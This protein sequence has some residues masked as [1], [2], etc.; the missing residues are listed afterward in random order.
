MTITQL[1]SGSYRIRQMYKG[2]TY[3]KVLPYKPTKKEAITIMAEMMENTPVE[4]SAAPNR[5]LGGAIEHFIAE[6]EKAGISPAS[7]RGY[8]VI[9]RNIPQK[10][11][12]IVTS[13]ITNDDVQRLVNEYGKTRTAKT[14][15]NMYSLVRSSLRQ[16]RPNLV[17]VCNLP[18]AERKAE[19]EPTTED[20]RRILEAAKGSRYEIVL[21]L[22]ALAV[23]RGE[24]I[25]VTAADLTGNVL[26]INKD[27]VLDKNENY[28]LKDRPKNESSNRRILLPDSLANLIREKG[29]AFEGNPH[30]INEYLHKLQDRLGIPRF[31]LH[32]MR[33]FAVAYL[34][35]EGFTEEQIMNWGGWSTSSV[36]KRAYRYNLD[37][38]ESQKEISNRLGNLNF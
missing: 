7:V 36:M 15:R 13:D 27:V 20:I 25:A 26:T 10:Y 19:Y 31:R 3:S 8:L 2:H 30:T 16:I 35:K 21:R 6:R 33:H 17:L 14:V 18:S 5:T 4:A 9:Y 28:V 34:H 38:E 12:N 37:P 29:V 1:P 22:A 32:M 23:R 11:K 24:A